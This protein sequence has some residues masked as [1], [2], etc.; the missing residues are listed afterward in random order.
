MGSV[1]ATVVTHSSMGT[2]PLSMVVSM[3]VVS[4]ERMFA[5]TP[6]PRPSERMTVASF[7]SHSSAH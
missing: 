6:L 5:L 3:V 7:P 4:V 1:S 2:L